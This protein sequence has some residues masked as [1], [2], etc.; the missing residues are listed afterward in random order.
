MPKGVRLPRENR[1][2]KPT[3][4]PTVHDIYWAAGLFEG[5]GSVLSSGPS[6][7]QKDRWVIDRLQALFGGNVTL[8]R[9]GPTN[10]RRWIYHWHVA[11]SRGR[12]FIWTIYCLLSPRRQEQVRAARD[13]E[14]GFLADWKHAYEMERL[15]RAD[16][17]VYKG[18]AIKNIGK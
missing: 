16:A 2:P 3:L 13:R 5:E 17:E 6:V 11:G 15:I 1:Q 14:S 4:R 12:G 8:Y 7:N 10:N 18:H 9:M